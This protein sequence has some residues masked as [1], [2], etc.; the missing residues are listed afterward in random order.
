MNRGSAWSLRTEDSLHVEVKKVRN[1]SSEAYAWGLKPITA[2]GLSL[3]LRMAPA[4]C[5]GLVEVSRTRL[6][7]AIQQQESK[8]ITI[9]GFCANGWVLIEYEMSRPTSLYKGSQLRGL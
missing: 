4:H 9:K 5:N 3:S 7:A 1:A 6:S 8:T 2:G